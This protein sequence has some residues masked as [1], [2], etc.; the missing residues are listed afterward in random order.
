VLYSFDRHGVFTLSEGKGL[1]GLGIK[2]GEIVGRTIFEV[3]GDQPEAIGALR[4]ALA[5]ETFTLELSFPS[6][7]TF[8]VSHMAMHDDAGVYAGTIGVLVDIT[9][10]KRAEDELRAS[11]EEKESLLKEVH[12]RVKNNLQVISSLLKLQARKVQTPDAQGFLRDTQNR[13][14]S[15]ALLHETLYRSGNLAKV[16][17]PQ[18]VKNVC[19]LVAR[20]HASGAEKIRLR[21]EIVDV[22]L[23]L[24]RAIPAGL[25]ISELVSNAFKHAFP[26]RSKGEI[27]VEVQSAPEHQLVLRVSDNGIGLPAAADPQNAETLGLLLVRNLTRQLD[28][29]MSVSSGQG[30]IIEIVFPA[31][32]S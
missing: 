25:I 15:M 16:G 5:G 6:G 22:T 20:S 27:L 13:I 11:L 29:H 7:G 3:Y 1:V 23:D 9:E 31:Q 21:H 19:T 18:Y 26:S 17:L 28:G 14:N 32:P 8:E 10:R 4:R 30:T 24:D 12:H 2:P